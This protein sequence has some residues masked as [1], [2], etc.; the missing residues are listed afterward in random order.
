MDK[1]L[2]IEIERRRMSER[3]KKGNKERESDSHSNTIHIQFTI[4]YQPSALS[5]FDGIFNSKLKLKRYIHFYLALYSI[6]TSRAMW[7][8]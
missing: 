6:Y 7:S 1:V 3:R 4:K 8:L 5:P 2:D